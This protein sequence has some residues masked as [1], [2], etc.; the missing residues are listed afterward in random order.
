VSGVIS[1]RADDVVE[2]LV[3]YRSANLQATSEAG[4]AFASQT[5]KNEGNAAIDPSASSGQAAV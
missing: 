1:E 3:R 4:S 5:A 2:F